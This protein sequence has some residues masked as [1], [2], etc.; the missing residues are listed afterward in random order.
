MRQNFRRVA[1]PVAVQPPSKAKTFPAP[2]RGWIANEG[3]ASAD[4][5][6]AAVLENWFPTQT[7]IRLRG[8]TL[9]TATIGTDSIT[10]GTFAVDANWTKGT[11]VTISAGAAHFTAAPSSQMFQTVAPVNGTIYKIRYTI[12]NY[13]A[14]AVLVR[15][16]SPNAN[17][18]SRTANGTYTEYLTGA[19]GQTAISFVSTGTTTLDIDNVTMVAQEPVVSEFTYVA[20]A[21]RK[22]FATS[23][24]AIFDVTSVADAEVPPTAAVSGLTGGYF[25][26]A[27]MATIGG[28]YLYAVNGSD[29]ARLY[30][31]STWLAVTGVS[32]PAITGV[33]TSTLS[34]V[35]AYRNRLF[36]VQTGTMNAWALPVD[37]IGGAAI[38]ISLAGVFKNGGSLL[39]GGSW[40]YD[41]GNGINDRCVFVSDNGE[42]AVFEGG[43]PSD[44]NDWRLTG[45]YDI[46]P[47]MGKKGLL[48]IGGDLLL[49]TQ[50][51]IVP[52]SQVVQKD[53]AALSLAAVTKNIEPEWRR[54]VISRRGLNWEIIKFPQYNMGIVSLPNTSTTSAYC[55]VV[56]LETGAWAKYTGWDAN[57]LALHDDWAYF[58]TSTGTIM[59]MEIG[60]SDNGTIYI[61]KYCGLFD[62]CK[63]IGFDKTVHSLRGTF[64]AGRTFIPKL[65][66]AVDYD[67]TFPTAP[68]STPDT[69]APSLWDVGLWDVA[70]WDAATVTPAPY[71]TRWVSSGKSGFVVAPQIQVTCGVTATPDAE[72]AQMDTVFDIGELVV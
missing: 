65:S 33:T 38:Q 31:G 52:M 13:S 43:D 46:T 41:A 37:S 19:T 24:T 63:A 40:S 8:G 9:K 26:S 51:G 15:L 5:G 60:G 49:I 12:S 45:R 16:T 6:G 48:Q 39:S 44:I 42:V 34:H 68:S 53:P 1:V 71:N 14:G 58:G 22:L 17:G 56:N 20:G 50:D 57:C 7:G 61:A 62:H 29:L 35:W 3:L 66:I 18:T 69:G 54:E 21:T 25:S 67:T 55:F 2:T 11:N 59:K 28:S 30:D 70:V 72:F 4:P 10:N 32:V 64:T 27:Q 36:F 47:I 23:A